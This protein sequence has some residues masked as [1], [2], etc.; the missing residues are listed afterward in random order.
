MTLEILYNL[1][2]IFQDFFTAFGLVTILFFILSI[3]FKKQE[4]NKIDEASIKFISF[5]GILYLMTWIVRI[6]AELNII[7]EEDKDSML[8]EMFG[9]YWFGFWLQPI[10]WFIITQVLRFEKI[11]RNTLLR[12]LFSILLIVSIERMVIISTS[13]H[14]DYLPS[15]WTMSNEL[16][17]YPSNLILALIIKVIIFLIF[18]TA[19]RMIN[20]KWRIKTE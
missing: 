17:F 19:F 10:L 1:S 3:F 13:F 6:V 12:I 4:I 8:N 5:I 16:S 14:R 9:K 18:V 15:S 2:L 11:R 7:N 20:K